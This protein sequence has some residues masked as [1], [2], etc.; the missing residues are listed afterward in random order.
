[1]LPSFCKDIVTRIRPGTKA[2][3]GSTVPDWEH[4]SRLDITGC[5]MQPASTTLSQDGRVLGISDS[6]TLF[7]PTVSDIKEGDRIEFNGKVYQV[8]GDVR[9]QP[10]AARLDHL[11]IGLRRFHG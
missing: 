5:S 4:A 7:A 6:Y 10:C 11:Q 2:V 1:M 9:I 3:R 8:E